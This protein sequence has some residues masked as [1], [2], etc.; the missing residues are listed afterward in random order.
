MEIIVFVILGFVVSYFFH[1]LLFSRCKSLPGPFAHTFPLS[2]SALAFLTKAKVHWKYYAELHKKYGKIFHIRIPGKD[3]IIVSSVPLVKEI[4]KD[5]ETF[6]SPPSFRDAVAF[7]LGPSMFVSEG[8]VWKGKHTA[9]Q[10]MLKQNVLESHTHLV[11]RKSRKLVTK[12]FSLIESTSNV[13]DVMPLMK[14]I[15][16]DVI[17]EVAFG[18][19]FH[20]M[21]DDITGPLDCDGTTCREK[22]T[23]LFSGLNRRLLHPTFL[24][25]FPLSSER[26]K[27]KKAQEAVRKVIYGIINDWDQKKQSIS[28]DELPQNLISLLLAIRDA[29]KSLTEKTFPDDHITGECFSFLSAGHDTTARTAGFLMHFLSINMECQE[30]LRDEIMEVWETIEDD[31]RP[32]FVDFRDMKYMNAVVRESQRL[33]PVAT[34]VARETMRDIELH[35]EDSQNTYFFPKGSL[36]LPNVMEIHNSEQHYGNPH[37]FYPERWLEKGNFLNS[38]AFLPFGIGRRSCFGKHLAI[39]EVK[40][41]MFFLLRH[42]VIKPAQPVE[43]INMFGLG[44]TNDS[45]FLEFQPIKDQSQL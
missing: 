24:W 7:A 36:V 1:C 23:V 33:T 15:T 25:D 39:L 43:L 20:T 28:D 37:K 41:I 26:Q 21:D 2:P 18:V 13:I 38:K 10:P 30:K 16:L 27:E 44:F 4:I 42:F 5:R 12:I 8:S 31:S 3:I 34:V 11:N 9:L 6:Q 19:D 32:N 14:S 22:M 40:S 29:E 35:D 45:F 17:G